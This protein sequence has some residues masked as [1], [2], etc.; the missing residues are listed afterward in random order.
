MNNKTSQ[1]IKPENSFKTNDAAKLTAQLTLKPSINGAAVIA[2]YGALFGSQDIGELAGL[3]ANSIDKVNSG[4]MTKC[5]AMLLSQAHAL[6]S[7]F[8]N[9]S[10][11]AIGQEYLRNYEVFLKLA[12]KAQSQ[13]RMTLET[14]AAIKNPPIVFARQAN[15]A[16][17]HQQINNA[18]MSSPDTH[19]K[20]PQSA[21]NELLEVN[22]E[23][24]LVTGTTGTAGSNDSELEAMA[25]VDR[26]KI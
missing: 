19:T 17:G 13:S 26:P 10:R 21:Q 23:Q 7:I 15:I 22:N 2:E 20:K 6:Q 1:E 16:N 9:L 24:W 12:L 8:V 18:S 4:D 3:L 25:G 14:L 11:R 5:E